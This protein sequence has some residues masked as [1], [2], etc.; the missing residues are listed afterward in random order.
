MTRT[1]REV[2]SFL[3]IIRIAKWFDLRE[4]GNA[5]RGARQQNHTM[6]GTDTRVPY[7]H[8]MCINMCNSEAPPGRRDWG[9]DALTQHSKWAKITRALAQ[10]S[11]QLPTSSALLFQID[12]CWHAEQT[13]FSRPDSLWGSSVKTRTMQRIFAWP[14]RQDDTHKSRAISNS[15]IVVGSSWLLVLTWSSSL[16]LILL[17]RILL[18]LIM[19]ALIN[20]NAATNDT[21]KLR[22]AT[23]S[24][25]CRKQH[26]NNNHTH[27]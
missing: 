14:L 12:R 21:S 16:S 9:K 10:V 2:E 13:C 3:C 19:P 8:Q 17:L 27:S 20:I 4:R 6:S 1:N 5:R 18:L 23:S 22:S 25:V 26:H 7:I 15:S 11:G 24:T